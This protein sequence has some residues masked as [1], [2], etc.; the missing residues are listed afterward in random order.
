VIR[1][2]L[3]RL[4]GSRPYVRPTTGEFIRCVLD[5]KIDLGGRLDCVT[6]LEDSDDPEAEAALGKVALDP[7]TEPMLADAVGDSLAIIW[8]RQ[9]RLNED[10]VKRLSGDALLGARNIIGALRPEWLS[11]LPSSDER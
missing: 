9:N 10:L 7:E 4:F 3:G 2:W 1:E 11:R 5:K 6:A 8:V